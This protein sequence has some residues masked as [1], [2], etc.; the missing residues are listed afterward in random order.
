[1]TGGF[2]TV[3]PHLRLSDTMVTRMINANKNGTLHIP[4]ID[5]AFS[6]RD[7]SSNKL[8]TT[9]LKGAGQADGG[10]TELLLVQGTS[11]AERRDSLE[12]TCDYGDFVHHRSCALIVGYCTQEASDAF[13]ASDRFKLLTC[14]DQGTVTGTTRRCMLTPAF[15]NMLERRLVKAMREGYTVRQLLQL[16]M[17]VVRAVLERSAVSNKDGNSAIEYVCDQ[18]T[19]LFRPS[20]A[21]GFETATE[22]SPE[23]SG[24]PSGGDDRAMAKLR[25]QNRQLTS[26]RDKARHRVRES[27]AHVS[28]RRRDDRSPIRSDDR[29]RDARDDSPKI[30]NDYNRSVGCARG[31]HCRYLHVCNRQGQDGSA[32]R[33]RHTAINH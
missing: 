10:D 18:R 8:F 1:V 13:L 5:K 31:I 16:D 4:C 32:C 20:K 17:V 9:I 29:R 25:E 3:E 24:A 22:P 15:I 6:Y 2:S 21:V 7:T 14:H 28:D 19:S 23:L 30:C 27:P 33:Q 26:E 11:A 12:L